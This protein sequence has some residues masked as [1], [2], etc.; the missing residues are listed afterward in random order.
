MTARLLHFVCVVALALAGTRRAFAEPPPARASAGEDEEIIVIIDRA[1]DQAARDRDRVLG[2]APFVTV[3]HPDEH[4]A[5]ASVADAVGQTVGV[6][7]RSLGGLGAYASISVRGAAPGHTQVSIDGVPLARIA[8]VTTDLGRFALDAFGEV[9]LYRGAVPV[10]LGGAGVGGALDLITR[11]GRGEHGE[12]VH[13]SFGA[14]SFGARHLHAHYGDDHLDGRLL[15]S[16]ALGYQGAGGDYTYFSDNG[17][18]L[19]KTD[20]HYESRRNNGFDQFDAAARAG[21]P[22][23]RLAAG[24]RVAWKQ[25]GLPGSIA[26]PAFGASLTTLDTIGDVHVDH[27][28][29]AASA[30][31]LAFALV[32][33]QRLD[34]PLAELGL[35]AQHRGYITISAGESSTWHVPVHGDRATAGVELRADAFR[36]RDRSGAMPTVTGDRFGAA[37][38]AAYDAALDPTVTVTPAVRLDFV[39]TA[40][41]P[42]DAGPQAGMAVPARWDVV[43]SPRVTMRLLATPD[44]AVKASGGWYVRLPTL[45][46]LFG[47]RGFVVGSPSLRPERGPSADLGGVWAPSRA[48]AGGSIDRVL[49]EADVFATRARD[50]IAFI[51]TAGYVARAANIGESETMGA[52]LVASARLVR[53]LSLTAS[54]T[55]IAS[56]QISVDP[57]RDGKPLPRTPEELLYA[58]ADVVRGRA[59]GWLDASVQSESF[60]DNAGLGR[61]PGR[62]LIGA[63]ARVEIAARVGVS[64][65]VANLAD[66][67]VVQLPLSPAPSPSFTT[68]PTALA[69]VAGYPLPGRS[70]YVSMDWSH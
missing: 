2:D 3:I 6:Q 65:A 7:T 59:A 70:F 1:P 33:T 43:P 54:Y 5:T 18:P 31:E 51:T 30:R 24:A 36:D 28:A 56:Q 50:T 58:R 15:S 13:A 62:V 22:D 67:R 68:T 41:T 26:Q 66:V 38:L 9:A 14:G 12:R 29:G 53:T 64:I 37:L 35:G 21:T 42:E 17:T 63:G 46:E 8:Q 32:E 20:D 45:V 47:D 61:V 23:R 55:R 11:L 57:N 27:E 52:E 48:L 34:D 4:P 39:H 49:V 25:Q 40:P 16:L 60:L 10:E 19:N 44:V 69:D